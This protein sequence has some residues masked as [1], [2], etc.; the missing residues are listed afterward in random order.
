MRL[1]DELIKQFAD[2]AAASRE[3]LAKELIEE[4]YSPDSVSIGD[5]ISYDEET[6]TMKY[7]CFAVLKK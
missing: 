2:E 1:L 6:H 3:M 5:R 4:G 7:E